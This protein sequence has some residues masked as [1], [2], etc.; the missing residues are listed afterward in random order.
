MCSSLVQKLNTMPYHMQCDQSL[1]HSMCVS[2]IHFAYILHTYFL[3]KARRWYLL[4]PLDPSGIFAYLKELSIVLKPNIIQVGTFTSA[5]LLMKW[6][7][8]HCEFETAGWLSESSVKLTLIYCKW[9]TLRTLVGSLQW[10]IGSYFVVHSLKYIHIYTCT[11]ILYI[12]I[13]K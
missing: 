6:R 4:Y 9:A 5:G 2:F 10:H 1:I 13:C 12:Y 7:L 3:D 8:F 11:Y